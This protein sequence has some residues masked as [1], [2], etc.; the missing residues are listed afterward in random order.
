MQSNYDLEDIFKKE[1]EHIDDFYRE[2]NSRLYKITFEKELS[3]AWLYKQVAN[4]KIYLFEIHNKD[5]NPK[6]I[7][8]KNLHT[9]YWEMLFD[10]KNLA[11][12]VFKLNGEA[13]VFY[14]KASI[15]KE[16]GYFIPLV[17]KLLKNSLG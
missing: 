12:V 1:Y 13:K 16:K 5:F 9:L 17:A 3:E 2:T 8:K 11:D 15:H 4:E 14:R 7:G 6:S 10:K